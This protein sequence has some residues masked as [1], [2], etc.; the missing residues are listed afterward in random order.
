MTEAEAAE[1][2]RVYAAEW[3]VPVRGLRL[4]RKQRA[5]WY[6]RI[7]WYEFEVDAGDGT[8]RAIVTRRSGV[9][10][11]DYRPVNPKTFML[12]M[13]AAHPHFTSVTIFWRMAP[14]EDYKDLWH[15][16]YRS[17]NDTERAAY[18]ARFP[19]PTDEQR[20]WAGFY[21]EIADVPATG[22]H[23]IAEHIIGRV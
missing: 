3:G 8:A 2:V 23:P 11:F 14:G 22:K 10:E 16:F 17:L 1:K 5:W 4:V 9:V 7:R 13:W 15:A 12:P 19:A 6:F 21:D 18:K 20:A